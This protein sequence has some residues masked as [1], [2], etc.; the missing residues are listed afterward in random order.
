V[1]IVQRRCRITVIKLIDE[2]RL[3]PQPGIDSTLLP[4]ATGRLIWAR[5][6]PHGARPSAGNISKIRRW[7]SSAPKPVPQTPAAPADWPVVREQL[8]AVIRDIAG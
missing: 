4:R 6:L 1:D 7:S 3:M 8:W 5:L 2:L